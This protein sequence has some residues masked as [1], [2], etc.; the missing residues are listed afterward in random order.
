MET[1]EI[2]K[3]SFL[4]K[5][6]LGVPVI[7]I[8]VVLAGG[9]AYYAW[10]LKSL[11]NTT[12]TDT[13][14]GDTTDTSSNALDSLGA[15]N[16][17]L[18]G[19][20]SST[21]VTTPSTDATLPNASIPDNDAWVNKGIE[22]LV[23]THKATGTAAQSA[24]LAYIGGLSRSHDQD[25]IVNLVIEHFGPPPDGVPGVGQV[26]SP[27]AQR[28]FTEFPGV[29]TVKGVNDNTYTELAKLYYG[30]TDN[31]SIDLLQAHNLSLGHAGPWSVGTKVSIPKYAPAK[32]YK[33]TSTTRTAAQI[34]AK[35]GISVA[36]LAELN[37]TVKFPVAIG[38]SVR[39]A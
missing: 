12:P 5:K 32:Y 30:R 26:T 28:Q 36:I 7:A 16:D 14:A 4:K 23:S 11:P 34:A 13:T 37:D 1:P 20:P 35:N 31:A 6:V 22:W 29:H 8:G 19:T 3:S 25:T 2:T 27:P 38:T 33:A 24:L 9:I 18:I 21:T 39:V 17:G 15:S 10:H